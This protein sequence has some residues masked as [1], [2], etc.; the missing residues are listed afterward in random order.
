MGLRGER[1]STM[2]AKIEDAQPAALRAY[3]TVNGIPTLAAELRP[4]F[5]GRITKLALTR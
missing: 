3:Y 1:D 4:L 5:E 2:F